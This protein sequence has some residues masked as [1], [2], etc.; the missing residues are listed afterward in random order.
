[1]SSPLAQRLEVARRQ[2]FVGR[3]PE[4]ERFQ[5]ALIAPELPFYV[6]H[7]HG[8]GGV[9]KTTLLR[10]FMFGAREAQVPV[11]YL[12]GRNI[13]PAPELF[14]GALH[15]ALAL[16]PQE[17]PLS[18]LA[19]Q[20]GRLVLLIDTYETLMPLDGWLRD[21]FLPQ[22]SGN[23]LTV[24]AGRHPPTLPWRTDPGWEGLVQIIPLRNLSPEETE[25]YLLKRFI[26]ATQHQ[27]VLAFTHGY[28]L[29]L[30]LVADAF[31]QNPQLI[32]KPES[33]PNLIKALLD[34]FVEKVPGPHHRA[35]LEACAL[36]RLTSEPLLAALLNTPDAHEYFGWLRG[37]S[38]IDTDRFGLF[39]HDL[40]R[41]ALAADLRWRN[42]EWYMELHTRA[43]RYYLSQLERHE[44]QGQ[45]SILFDY[46]FLH[47]DNPMVRPFFEWKQ[48]GTVF[49]DKMQA[50]DAAA[51][52]AMISTHEGTEAR[53]IATYWLNRQPQGV[54]L[55][56]DGSGIVQGV[57]MLIALE[58]ITSADRQQD[59][60][61]QAIW[62]FWHKTATIRPGETATAFRFWLGHETYQNVSPVQSRIFLNMV[63]H[64][65][66]T[67]GLTYTFLPCAQ[68]EFWAN[69]FA[70]ADLHRLEAADFTVGAHRYGVYGHDW[71]AIPPMAWLSLMAEREV[72]LG[73]KGEP[74][75]PAQAVLLLSE[76]EFSSALRDAL[77][78]FTHLPALF[79]NPLLQSRL[80]W[81]QAGTDT[82]PA[83]RVDV[84]RQ[85]LQ[86]AAAPLQQSL[87]QAKLYR[88]LYHTYFQPAATQEEAAELLDVPFST[89]RRHLRAGLEHIV[90]V[91]WQ[92]ELG[93]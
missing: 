88:A 75:K 22:L 65:L 36:V 21:I 32:F 81:Q 79:N 82:P 48:S 92:Q 9:G 69:I 42:A 53:T 58:Q 20:P 2:R 38:F 13:D 54:Q 71:R 90:T 35:A 7:V 37:L 44:G 1:M 24:L 10:Q 87:K 11:I 49:V 15:Q 25:A 73:L 4:L 59:P 66:T 86:D 56:R 5:A 17:Q 14:L 52:Q 12:D 57:L 31:A 23:I 62:Q 6:I 45:Q 47:R 85:L 50:N 39:P 89:Y 93:S 8:P 68:P 55:L 34:H 19:E 77:R 43:R 30:S 61:I 80:V 78:D 70:Y 74:P 29:A 83:R 76:A 67:P 3:S 33:A 27:D 28:P 60:G 40:A 51:I 18:Y 91:L 63:Q 46:V 84:L 41:E 26:P 64:Y 16:T 72:A